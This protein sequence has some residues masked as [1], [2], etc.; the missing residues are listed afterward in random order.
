MPTQA[1]DFKMSFMSNPCFISIFFVDI[2]YRQDIA[3]SSSHS[4]HIRRRILRQ[5]AQKRQ[6]LERYCLLTD[7]AINVL[8]QWYN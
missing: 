1:Q 4:I 3:R 7:M 6:A 2:Y 5:P 8:K